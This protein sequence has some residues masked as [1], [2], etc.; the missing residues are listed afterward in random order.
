MRR[1]RNKDLKPPALFLTLWIFNVTP[2]YKLLEVEDKEDVWHM[3][4]HSKALLIN[5][6]TH[7]AQN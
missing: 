2:S 3:V 1:E 7:E 5:V 6:T 4:P